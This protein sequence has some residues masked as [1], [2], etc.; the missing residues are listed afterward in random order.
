M[1][2]IPAD[3][4]REMAEM[5]EEQGMPSDV[6]VVAGSDVEP[7]VTKDWKYKYTVVTRRNA[8]ISF[9]FRRR[10][11][12]NGKAYRLSIQTMEGRYIQRFFNPDDL[13][14]HFYQ[15]NKFVGALSDTA[16]FYFRAK[17]VR[18]QVIGQGPDTR[19]ILKVHLYGMPDM[20]NPS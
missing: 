8:W 1:K 13:K 3:T 10:K 18:L 9:H 2:F 6:M 7:P 17:K 16:K 12:D 20:Q 5:G 15:D 11:G 19:Y 4:Y 14:V